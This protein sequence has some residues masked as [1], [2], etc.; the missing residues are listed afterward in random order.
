MTASFLCKILL[1]DW[2]L[3]ER[4]FADKLLD[5]DLAA[6]NGGWQWSSSSG[7]DAQPYFRIF[8]PYAQSEKFD[9]QGEF[10]KKWVPELAQ[11]KGKDI[12]KPD[13]DRFPD[14][15]EPIVDYSTNR[16]RCLVMYR[17]VRK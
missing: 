6:N 4:Y 8:N 13:T 3:G 7:V 11:A 16:E 1:V 17:V 14:Y 9:K 15:Q 12:H 2:K 10:I 5:Y